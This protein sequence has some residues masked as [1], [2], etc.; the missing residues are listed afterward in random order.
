M[1]PIAAGGAA[2]QAGRQDAIPARP[3][4]G[5]GGHHGPFGFPEI[6]MVT[7]RSRLRSFFIPNGR[8]FPVSPS[9]CR[10]RSGVASGGGGGS[11]RYDANAVV[12]ADL[13]A[14]FVV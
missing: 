9:A 11:F 1:G 10:L 13:A 8:W 6:F 14:L 3:D 12:L 2:H 5:R 7:V 4:G